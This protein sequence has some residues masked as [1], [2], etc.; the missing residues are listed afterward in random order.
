MTNGNQHTPHAK[1]NKSEMKKKKRR[2][3][4]KNTKKKTSLQQQTAHS[5][6]NIIL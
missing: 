3:K 2:R 5:I 4:K 6:I 1:T